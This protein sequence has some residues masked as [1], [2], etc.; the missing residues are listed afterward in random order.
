M[1][2]IVGCYMKHSMDSLGFS[3]VRGYSQQWRF[4][5]LLF[6]GWTK[7]SRS[8]RRRVTVTG[9]RLTRSYYWFGPPA[10]AQEL[11]SSS[12]RALAHWH[13][14]EDLGQDSLEG[15][16]DVGGLERRCLKEE[17]SLLLG[18]LTGVLRGH[19]PLVLKVA[20]VADQHDHD[21]LVSVAAQLIQPPW[22]VVKA[23]ALGYVVHQKGPNCASLS[24]Y[25]CIITEQ[26]NS[27]VLK[28][29]QQPIQT[30][31]Y[32][33]LGIS[34]SPDPTS[35]SRIRSTDRIGET[36]KVRVSTP[37]LSCPAVSQIWALMRFC[38][39]WRVRVWNSTPMVAL[40]S[41]LNSLRANRARICDFPTA[42]S[43]MSTT[44]NT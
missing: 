35:E 42:E 6:S 34:K 15:G 23:L 31:T 12:P 40:E 26:L 19:S 28:S 37:H 30:Y 16:L 36:G 7:S 44:L 9:L 20:L 13:S 24:L 18:E 8:D 17:E 10:P 33:T 1:D 21:V 11:R 22:D 25:Y 43:P 41:R 3:L 2:A 32:K 14:L 5:V 39:I 38:W 27:T 29:D 4:R